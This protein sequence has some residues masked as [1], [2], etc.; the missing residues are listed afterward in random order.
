M[1]L[2][3]KLWVLA[4]AQAV[5]PTAAAAA[6]AQ[7]EAAATGRLE[8]WVLLVAWF[9]TDQVVLGL[10]HTTATQGVIAFMVVAGAAVLWAIR[11]IS[12]EEARGAIAC[13][14]AAVAVVLELP[15]AE[16][17][18]FLNV[19]VMAARVASTTRQ[20]ERPQAVAAAVH[21]KVI[22]VRAHAVRPE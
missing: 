20:T 14:V 11:E 22:L 18:A 7:W 21:D 13:S 5:Q 4:A 9:Y 3:W 6:A 12:T 17:A 19:P 15:L 10:K 8:G 1:G 2:T 16:L